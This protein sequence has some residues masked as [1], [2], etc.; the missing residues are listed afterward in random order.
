MNK[1]FNFLDSKRDKLNKYLKNRTSI[2]FADWGMLILLIAGLVLIIVFSISY[3]IGL[4]DS[5]S[6]GVLWFTGIVI[7]KY[8]EETY[9]LKQLQ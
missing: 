6:I 4:K 3:G 9:W 7:L 1:F 2:G 8:T 5:A